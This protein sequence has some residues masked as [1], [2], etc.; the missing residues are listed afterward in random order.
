MNFTTV[1]LATP[2]T[3]TMPATFTILAP[4]AAPFCI[5]LAKNADP[6]QAHAVLLSR[7]Y[8]VTDAFTALAQAAEHGA[9]TRAAITRATFN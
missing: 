8:S 1:K 2:K 6:A 7:G 5:T 4:I 3:D 9:V